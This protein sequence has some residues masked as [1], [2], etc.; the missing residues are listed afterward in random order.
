MPDPDEFD[1]AFAADPSAAKALVDAAGAHID[2]VAVPTPRPVDE[3]GVADVEAPAPDATSAP[4]TPV[5]AADAAA[6]PAPTEDTQPPAPAAQPP[7]PAPKL[8]PTL[9]IAPEVVDRWTSMADVT[10]DDFPEPIRPAVAKALEIVANAE[11][12]AQ[13]S[14]AAYDTII[15]ELKA[16]GAPGVG[17]AAE[18]TRQL[19]V[20]LGSLRTRD[21]QHTWQSFI[22]ANADYNTM[23]REVRDQFSKLVETGAYAHLGGATQLENLNRAFKYVKMEHGYGAAAPA[24]TSAAGVPVPAPVAAP[25]AKVAPVATPGQAPGGVALAAKGRAPARAVPRPDTEVS[26]EDALNEFE[27]LLS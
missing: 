8:A 14:K 26:L 6:A 2:R 21:A 25:A 12:A 27:H 1:R 15:A 13:V 7:A 4:A 17:E 20:E 11:A 9:A 19:Y 24:A 3:A 16:K 5:A 10:V 18:L 23:P 22:S